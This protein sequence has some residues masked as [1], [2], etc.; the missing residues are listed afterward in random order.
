MEAEEG[1]EV[2]VRGATRA[3]GFAAHAVGA[4]VAGA[5]SDRLHPRSHGLLGRDEDRYLR[6]LASLVATALG[7][8]PQVPRKHERTP[9]DGCAARIVRQRLQAERFGQGDFHHVAAPPRPPELPEGA[10]VVLESSVLAAAGEFESAGLGCGRDRLAVDPHREALTRPVGLA[11]HQCELPGR[12]RLHPQRRSLPLGEPRLHLEADAGVGPVG[13]GGRVQIHPQPVPV[14]VVDSVAVERVAFHTR[15]HA[16]REAALHVLVLALHAAAHRHHVA[17]A[18]VLG[19]DGRHDVV[20]EGA[21]VEVR[22][23]GV[24]PQ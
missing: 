7:F 3:I 13:G 10:G 11:Q 8:G 23:V 12:A 9:H 16:A 18:A 4:E 14:L 1:L 17:G 20:E 19:V 15:P 5:A 22:V 2:H 24:G 21:L 6:R